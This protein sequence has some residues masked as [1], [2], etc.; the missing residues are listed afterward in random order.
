MRL[1]NILDRWAE[2][3]VAV[4]Q[5]SVVL[6]DLKTPEAAR[7]PFALMYEE[8]ARSLSVA[9]LAVVAGTALATGR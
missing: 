8:L 2:G 3:D 7:Y 4:G 1:E 5:P 9:G 6:T